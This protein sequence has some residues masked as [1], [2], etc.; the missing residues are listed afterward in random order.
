MGVLNCRVLKNGKCEVSQKYKGTRHNGIDL[1][2]AGYTLDNVVAHSDGTVVGVVSNINYN[3]SKSGRRIYGNYV[4]IKHDNGMYT[5]YA[6][7][8][9]GS[10]A[11]SLNQ[12]VTKGQVLGY[13]GN[14]GYSF[15]AHLHFEV[16]NANNV[17]I[18]P[19]T[20][21]GAELPKPTQSTDVDKTSTTYTVKAGDT[22]SGIASKYGTTYQELAR[23]N[24]IA[25]PNVI[26]PGQ[27]IKIN[28]GTV[29]KTYTVKS[30]DTLSGI[31]SKY[32][33]TWQKLYEKNKSVIGNDPNLIKPG[34][35][36]K[37]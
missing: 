10:V 4:K 23:I 12:R 11:V 37:I 30:G 15:G 17:Q 34:Q 7:L 6:H 27:V 22:L 32:G 3:T 9:Y 13:M 25:N 14:T 36:L 8:K 26:Y 33:T 28:R 2:G 31:A 35:V 20:Y 18:D 1:V 21:V 16:R 5:F 24:N 19:T 29:E